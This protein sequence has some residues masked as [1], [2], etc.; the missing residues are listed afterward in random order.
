MRIASAAVLL[1]ISS[2][3]ADAFSP[4]AP[5]TPSRFVSE[6]AL[7]MNGMQWDS[8]PGDK[9]GSSSS[10]SG[11]MG[12]GMGSIS[13][14]GS[15]MDGFAR[16]SSA[17]KPPQTGPTT[18]LRRANPN[19]NPN[20][21]HY[22]GGNNDETRGFIDLEQQVRQGRQN[23]M[24]QNGGYGGG[25]NFGVPP[26]RGTQPVSPP[27]MRNGGARAA[28][29][30][31]S[32]AA[33]GG[34]YGDYS[35]NNNNNNNNMGGPRRQDPLPNTA[36]AP[37]RRSMGDVP[38]QNAGARRV[39]RANPAQQQRQQNPYGQQSPY[40]PPPGGMNDNYYSREDAAMS[41]PD[42]IP[43]GA[44]IS[45]RSGVVNRSAGIRTPA[46][47]PTSARG[48]PLQRYQPPG[49]NYY[50]GG[51]PDDIPVSARTSQRNSRM[52][53]YSARPTPSGRPTLRNPG[54]ARGGP[55]MDRYAITPQ[56]QAGVPMNAPRVHPNDEP[57][58]SRSR[59]TGLRENSPYAAERNGQGGYIRR[60]PGADRYYGAP[61]VGGGLRRY[62]QPDRFAMQPGYGD[63]MDD[64]M[65]PDDIPVGARRAGRY[66][67]RRWDDAYDRRGSSGM[68]YAGPY[69]NAPGRRIPGEF[70]AFSNRNRYNEPEPGRYGVMSPD[71]YRDGPLRNSR[72]GRD[73][74]MG[75]Y[76]SE[77]WG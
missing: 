71:Y 35:N 24:A 60:G 57:I 12:S 52:D 1:L 41:H 4:T 42:D 28:P 75:P 74:M 62:E 27:G 68:P 2:F 14:M 29:G 6:W 8:K 34:M 30:Y 5:V 38:M 7:N 46:R 64:R 59:V 40:G 65:H 67:P 51:H 69:G 3:S 48:A 36:P 18:R 21:N 55:M 44:R 43:V 37:P 17:S 22:Q 73:R 56:Y 53:G 25:N 61:G 76:P 39:M 16:P 72:M 77:M 20:P 15:P 11:G 32:S 31:G 9:V 45:Q 33:P 66:A 58:N 47:R 54:M 70:G 23:M 63:Y 13:N 50:Q 49:N 19:P 26:P 10:G